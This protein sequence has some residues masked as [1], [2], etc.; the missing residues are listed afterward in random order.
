[1][2]L[3][4]LRQF[5]TSQFNPVRPLTLKGKFLVGLVRLL[6]KIRK[7]LGGKDW[8]HPMKGHHEDP[9]K[10]NFRQ[11][12]YF[13]YKYYFQ[14]ILKGDEG[15]GLEQHFQSQGAKFENKDTSNS[16]Q[17]IT[18]SAGGDLMPYFCITSEQCK[19]LWEESGDFFFDA[20]LVVGNLETPLNP[21][22]P[23][24]LVPEV[25]L[26]NMYFN[27]NQDMFEVY[28]GLGKY[29]GFDVLATANNHSLDQGEDGVV[30]TIEFLDQ[31][32]IQH[33]G[34]ARSEN[35]RDA[36]PIIEKNGIKIAF[37]SY[38]FSLNALVCPEGKAYLANHLNLN[39]ANPDLSLIMHQA[40]LARQ[41]GAE[42]LVAFLHM[43]CAYQPYPS[44]TIV[45]NMQQIC[46]QTGIDLVLGG[47]PHN[48]QPI[49][50][51][52]IKDPFSGRQKQSTIIYSQGDFVAYD[53]HK[54][55]KLPLLLKFDIAKINGEVVISAIRAKLFYNYAQLKNGKVESL[56]LLDYA[57]LRENSNIL[58]TDL[59]AQHEFE[60]LS[61]FAEA[62]LLKGNLER[63]LVKEERDGKGNEQD[64]NQP[65]HEL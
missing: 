3:M 7:T 31:K 34:T 61:Y 64:A 54:W 11:Q 37:L 20:D 4:P 47:H 57:H 39:E 13:G 53:I 49:E 23:A 21:K 28:S 26:S 59:P 10:M 40:Q 41:K 19:N 58:A 16:S 65:I 44:Q 1:M 48:A 9:R 46:R 45:D 32:E 14:A 18:L 42:F 50:F 33:V 17:K 27:A 63:F 12:L 52:E 35:E 38:T 62:F 25:M 29:K 5:P 22:K 36:F 6:F 55:C 51:L 60:E 15:A 43:G 2:N 8:L 24:S 56:R 30:Q